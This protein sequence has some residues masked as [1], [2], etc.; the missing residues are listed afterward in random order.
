[1]EILNILQTADI[2]CGLSIRALSRIAA[3][4]ETAEIPEKELLIRTGKEVERIG[5]VLAGEAEF[6]IRDQAGDAVRF[7]VLNQGEFFGEMAA[8]EN[9]CALYDIE[10]LTPMTV[11]MQSRE[12]F[13]NILSAHSAVVRN[14]YRLNVERLVKLCLTLLKHEQETLGSS[15][16]PEQ[17]H[18]VTNAVSYIDHNFNEQF[19]LDEIARHNN[20]S[21]FHFARR[22]KVVTGYSFKE[23]LN[24]K[25]VQEAKALISK[26]GMN[27]SEACY[28]VGFNDLSY[29]GRVFKRIA[30]KTPSDY[31]RQLRF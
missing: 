31:R 28:A 10:A 2:F 13:L 16:Y 11:L 5:I 6:R 17:I 12:S 9:G 8:V 14:A 22:F 3:S 23:Y 26:N 18:Y 24:R 15:Q 30:G 29:F 1:M 20:V 25:R 19:T 27:I 4:F 21:K 7:H